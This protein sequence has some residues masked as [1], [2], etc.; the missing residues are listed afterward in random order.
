MKSLHHLICK[1]DKQ[2]GERVAVVTEG[3][4]AAMN[5]KK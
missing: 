2:R 1:L 5:E 3:G 4:V